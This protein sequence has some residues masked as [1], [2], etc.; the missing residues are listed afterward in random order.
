MPLLL[1]DKTDFPIVRLDPA[2]VL[3]GY[4]AAWCDE[5]DALLAEGWPF[6]L[7]YPASDRH[8]GHEDRKRRGLWLKANKDRLAEVCLAMIIVEPDVGKRAELESIFPNLVRAFGT[9]QAACPSREDAEALG[10][11][12]LSGGKLRTGA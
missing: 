4:A 1:H 8:E 10:R 7:I 3:P 9:P 12:V 2:A 6:V 11:H 5:M